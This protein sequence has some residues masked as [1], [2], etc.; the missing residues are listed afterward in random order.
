V[1]ALVLALALVVG[2]QS[3]S[4]AAPAQKRFDSLDE[5]VGTF[6]GALRTD[7]RKALTEMLGPGG[8]ALVSSGDSVADRE[9]YAHFVAEYDKKHRLEGGG[10]QVVLHVGEDDFPLP[11]PLVPDGPYWRW[12][13]AAGRAEILARRIGRNELSAIQVCLAYVDAQREY[14]AQD[15][16]GQGILQYAQYIGSRPGRRDGLYWETRPGEPPSPL[17]PLVAR[18]RQ[19]GYGRPGQGPSTYHGYRYR[20]LTS[21]GRDAP[22]GAYDYIADK[23]MIGGFALVAAPAQYAVSGV[24]TFI[25]NHDGIV[26][27]RDL[28]PDTTQLAAAMTRFNP[29]S[30]WHRVEPR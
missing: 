17:G 1:T 21:Q 10:G 28:G 5:A 4:L 27:Q 22:G 16:M 19:A 15:R 18:A 26:Y 25:V 24:M 14:Y 9:A 30:S 8:R 12:D 2:V 13:A 3:V 20:V 23:H 11:I 6:I 7:D 29:D